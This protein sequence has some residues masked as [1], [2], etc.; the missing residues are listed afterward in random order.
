MIM[1]GKP[2]KLVPALIGGSIMGV[3]SSV[4]IINLGNCL[5]CMWVIVGGGVGAYFYW[6]ELTPDAE[7]PAG[8]GALVGL[9]SGIFGALFGTLI[10]YFFIAATGANWF[11]QIMEGIIE[12][13]EDVPPEFEDLM[14]TFQEEGFY[15]SFFIFIDLFVKL[16]LNSIFG[17]LGGIIGAAILRKR[18]A[19][20]KKEADKK[21]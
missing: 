20:D 1:E 4:P 17:T 10:G 7:F 5:C 3:L 19:S 6:R 2:S 16:I 13:G 14:E 8:E 9:L 11:Q 18:K 21:A 15:S 12:S